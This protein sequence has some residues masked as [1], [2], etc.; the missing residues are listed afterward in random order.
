MALFG[1]LGTPQLACLRSWRRAGVP[2][3]FLH[4]G[5]APLPW[6]VRWL[7]GVPCVQLGPQALD[8]PR[9]MARLARVLGEQRVDAITCVSESTGV[10]LWARRDQLPARVRVATVR[11]DQAALLAS[12]STQQRLA[13]DSG[14]KTLPTWCVPAGSGAPDLP[15]DAFPLV[16]RPDVAAQ[17][18][19]PFKVAVVDTREALAAWLTRRVPGS[20]AVVAQPLVVGPNLLVH[21]WRSADGQTCEHVA[22]RVDVKHQGL[23]VS[24]VPAKLPPDVENGCRR[25]AA[26]LG[27]SGVFH[28]DFVI[29]EGSGECHHLD[30]NPRLGGTTGKVLAAGYDEPMALVSTLSGEPLERHRLLPR[31]PQRAGALHQALRALVSAWRG[32]STAADH[33]SRDRALLLRR[34]AALLLDGRDELVRLDALPS[35]AGFLLYQVVAR[36][37]RGRKGP[38]LRPAA[39]AG[40]AAGVPGGGGSR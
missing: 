22:F 8:D 3:V 23:G 18:E 7:L 38:V 21:G 11:P 27:L 29:D 37:W 28:H 19:P 14:L 30:L 9:F 17:A 36:L 35:L 40:A 15:D 1:R 13:R 4:V 5:P 10:A 31:M 26:T 20:S 6:P 33:P 39:A 16:L 34:V 32:R 2:C 24:I 25:L 12:K